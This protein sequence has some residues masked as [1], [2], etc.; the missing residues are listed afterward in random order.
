MKGEYSPM[1]FEK[2]GSIFN[3][4]DMYNFLVK[5]KEL[6]KLKE[7]K[8]M[9]PSVIWNQNLTEKRLPYFRY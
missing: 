6:K 4:A 7:M 5:P 9:T 8:K 2:F 3:P 1:P